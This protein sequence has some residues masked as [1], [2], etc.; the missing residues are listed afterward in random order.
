MYK[1]LG[2]AVALCRRVALAVKNTRTAPPFFRADFF[3]PAW[4]ASGSPVF[5]LLAASPDKESVPRNFNRWHAELVT[6]Y[7]HAL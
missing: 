7:S 5:A 2:A 6:K 1:C 3:A 4:L